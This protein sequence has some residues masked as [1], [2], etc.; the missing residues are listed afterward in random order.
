MPAALQARGGGLGVAPSCAATEQQVTDKKPDCRCR[1]YAVERRLDVR[2]LRCKEMSVVGKQKNR[3]N[4]SLSIA[5]SG[6]VR[7]AP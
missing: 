1:A 4:R 3:A 2:G 6:L 7:G 5:R